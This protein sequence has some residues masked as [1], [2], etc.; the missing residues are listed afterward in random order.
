[1]VA[2][3]EETRIKKTGREAQLSLFYSKIQQET[4]TERGR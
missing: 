1:M 2:L 4:V 3:P